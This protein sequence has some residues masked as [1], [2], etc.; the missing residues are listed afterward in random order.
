MG[1]IIC[2]CGAT[3]DTMDEFKKHREV[4]RLTREDIKRIKVDI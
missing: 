2:V 3:F 4:C 1:K